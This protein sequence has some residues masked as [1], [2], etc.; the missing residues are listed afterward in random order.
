[1]GRGN[2]SEAMPDE[3]TLIDELLAPLAGPE[4]LGLKDDAAVLSPRS[5]YD[6]VFT[7]DAIAEGRHYLPND[8]PDTVARKLLRVNLSDLAAKGATPL[9]YLLSCAWSSDTSF[10]WMKRFVEGLRQDQ[11]EFG[12][13]LW[14]GDTIKTD[15][16]SVFSLTA[17]GEVPIGRI[18]TRSGAQV[19]DDLWVTGTIGDAAQGLRA[20]QGQL[21]TLSAADRDVLI[22]R[23]RVPRPPVAF[24]SKLRGIASA[25]IDVSDGLLADLAHLCEQSGVG[26]RI[27]QQKFPLSEAVKRCLEIDD[28][29]WKLVFGGGDDYQI[30]LAAPV[31]KKQ[32][33]LDLADQEGVRI[34]RIGESTE[35]TGVVLLGEAGQPI[36][37][38]P[39]GFNHFS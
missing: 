19:G 37:A 13:H 12:L 16:P 34:S 23:Y 24:G 20:A 14:G 33:I 9:G 5:G 11:V 28:H 18:V 30:L 15:G 17:I 3:F 26:A 8:P 32:R 2:G 29:Q 39:A 21:D 6:L 10:E 27:E 31:D 38:A 35:E 4:G 25:A 1:M 22:E 7:K 36:D